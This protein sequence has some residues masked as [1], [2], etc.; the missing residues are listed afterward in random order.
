MNDRVG[1]KSSFFVQ[2]AAVFGRRPLRAFAIFTGLAVLLTLPVCFFGYLEESH[3]V[4]LSAFARSF[5][6]D[7]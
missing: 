1:V 7:E 4:V 5:P 6:F 3:R 2:A